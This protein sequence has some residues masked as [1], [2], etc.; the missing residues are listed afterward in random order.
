[1]KKETSRGPEKGLE[2]G[3]PP[4]T[5]GLP[6]SGR[7]ALAALLAVLAISVAAYALLFSGQPDNPAD[8][9]EFYAMLVSSGKVGIVYDVRGADQLQA[10]AIYQCGVDIISK[11]RFAGKSLQNIGCSQEGCI[12]ASSSGNGTA[13]MS[14]EQALKQVSG[15]PYILV[16]PG[17]PAYNF[18]Q[19]HMEISIGKNTTGNSTCDIS[20]TEG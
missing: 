1:M 7:N 2:H 3:Q 13:R 11:G 4:R 20:A 12:A 18:F 17:E 10:S 19:R 15:D 8:G 16:K 9:S 14:Y 6:E 5:G